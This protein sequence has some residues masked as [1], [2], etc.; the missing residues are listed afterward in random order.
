MS[1]CGAPR[2]FPQRA[3]A[4]NV[5]ATLRVC[6]VGLS[7]AT[8]RFLLAA[9]AVALAAGCQRA[10]RQGRK[11][12]LVQPEVITTAS[13]FEMVRL[14]AGIFV[15]GG[16]GDDERPA[17]EVV[18][19][20]FLIDRFEVTQEQ[21]I[22]LMGTN[23]AKFKGSKRPVEMISWTDAAM[24]C[25]VRSEAEGLEPCYR[26]DATCNLNANGY[27]LPTE[28]EWEYACRAGSTGDYCFGNDRRLLA[29]YAWYKGNSGGETHPVGV[30][31]PNAWS[32]YDMHGNVAEWC[33]DIYEANY[34]ARSPRR[35][36]RGPEQGRMYV[37]R[38]GSWASSAEACR[39]AYRAAD[40]PG[41]TDACF[42]RETI[43][44]RCVRPARRR[45]SSGE[46]AG[47]D[48][49]WLPRL[50]SRRHAWLACCSE[51]QLMGNGTPGLA[52]PTVVCC[53]GSGWG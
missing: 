30:K 49:A 43:G 47:K 27:R 38:G 23:P 35:N 13:G 42:P 20:E 37:V 6:K 14:P 32:I 53:R 12:R 34:Y 40:N 41:F 2:P 24:F 36:P 17:H 4:G 29:D 39:C 52:L 22:K 21:Y 48:T 44:F 11:E 46:A 50:L 25:N 9:L 33:N 45:A 5:H 15:M 28:A 18:L 3:R 7:R 19:D 8:V 10:E 26:E 1:S 16:K 51:P 31:K